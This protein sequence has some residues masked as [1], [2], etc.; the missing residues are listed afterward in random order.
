MLYLMTIVSG[1]RLAEAELAIKQTIDRAAQQVSEQ[2]YQLAQDSLAN[3]L[4]SLFETNR[5]MASAFM[6]LRE[7]R[8]APDYFDQRVRQLAQI[9]KATMQA[10]AQKFLQAE[11]LCTIKVGRV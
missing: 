4:C 9:S 3:S 7:Y 10:T 11:R 5:Q 2:E 1:D 6:L 8:F